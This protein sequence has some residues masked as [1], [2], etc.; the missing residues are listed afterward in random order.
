MDVE[1]GAAP[2]VPRREYRD[3]ETLSLYN[4]TF[5]DEYELLLLI[6]LCVSIS[7]VVFCGF[8]MGAVVT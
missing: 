3:A 7:A 2:G 6:S 1:D 8:G 4:T 5:N